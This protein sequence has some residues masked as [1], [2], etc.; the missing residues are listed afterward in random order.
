[1]SGLTILEK[2]CCQLILSLYMP[3]VVS[4]GNARWCLR[5]MVEC[6]EIEEVVGWDIVYVVGPPRSWGSEEQSAE[7]RI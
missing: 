4:G 7:A 2:G 6:G 1:M 5:E 3:R